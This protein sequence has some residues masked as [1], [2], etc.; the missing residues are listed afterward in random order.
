MRHLLANSVCFCALAL[1]GSLL[2]QDSPKIDF[3]QDVRPLL[4]QNCVSCHGPKQQNGGMRLD[5]KS[6][7]MKN[8]RIVPGNSAN[9]ML[10]HR[11]SD[12][13][14]GMQMPP[15]GELPAKDIATIKRW[16]DA[17][18]EWPDALSVEGDLPPLDPAAVA[19]VNLLPEGNVAGFLGAMNRK[20]ALLNARGPEGSTPFMYAVMYLDT[21][22]LARLLKLGADPNRHNDADATALM[23][24]ARDLGKVR[25]LV[26]HGADV[27]AVSENLRTPLMV[28]ARMP[29]GAPVVKFLL[30]HGA[31]PN[32]NAHPDAASSP[33][34]EAATAGS[35]ESFRLLLDRGAKI[36]DDAAWILAAAVTTHCTS[37][38][39]LAVAKTN[40]KDAYTAALLL[41]A[42]LPDAAAIKTMLDHGADVNVSDPFGHTALMYAAESDADSLE[43]VKLLV[44][45][46][47]KVNARST[48][49][50]S[51]DS[52]LSIL[53][54]AKQ[55]GD[56][57]VVHFLV[58]SGAQPSGAPAA[59]LHLRAKNDVRSAIQDSLPLLQKA[60]VQFAKNSGCVSCHN[61][62]LTAMAIS[63][64]RQKGF[65]VDEK[66]AS[67]Q[68]K[69]NVEMLSHTRDILHQGVLVPVGDNFSESVVGY[70][71]MGL[72]AEGY[73]PDLDTDNAAMHMLSRQQA[74]GH[75]DYPH[76]DTRQPLCQDYIGL[77]AKAMRGLQLY[78]PKADPAPYRKA[79]QMAASWLASANSFNNDDRSWRVAGLA[80]A[81]NEKPALKKA[82]QELV[83]NQK[84]D[85]GW[86]DLPTMDS[87]AY[88]TGKSLVA[89]HLAGMAASDPVYR[90]GIDWLLKHQDEDGSW[91]VPTRALAFQPWADA[92]FPHGYDQFISSAG[93]DWAAMALSL[94]LPAPNNTT[95]SRAP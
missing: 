47:A 10:F 61:N 44:A 40:N 56:T 70:M 35:A 6:S 25:L 31:N 67:A 16:I 65:T 45:H 42:F 94:A 21:P 63:G 90:R 24:G 48:H 66:V 32:P 26:A 58:A 54:M 50:N 84:P 13:Q 29:G 57:P 23:W 60:D 64:A 2:A 73:K 36:G 87:T 59:V 93:T 28:A 92:G 78:A 1:T 89:L 33:L 3:A 18:A 7:A 11:V 43:V 19:A 12:S 80:W 27:N 69:V 9:S 85:G 41:T 49:A 14:F 71:L 30:E 68:V 72:H 15:T 38:F 79:V 82:V 55:H 86:S 52:G 74:D 39:D 77:T 20:P 4:Q 37:C 75:W 53:D 76:A 5:R 8:R 46:G 17:G 22:T 95:A 88:A 62:S 91:Y 81:G 34:L 51:G 83:A